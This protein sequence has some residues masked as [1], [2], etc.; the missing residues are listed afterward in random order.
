MQNSLMKLMRKYQRNKIYIVFNHD[1]IDSLYGIRSSRHPRMAAFYRHGISN[2]VCGDDEGILVNTECEINEQPELDPYFTGNRLYFHISDILSF[3]PYPKT[4][5]I[6][7]YTYTLSN[8]GRVFTCH[9]TKLWRAESG[10]L[11]TQTRMQLAQSPLL[12]TQNPKHFSGLMYHLWIPWRHS[13]RRR[14][15]FS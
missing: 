6:L 12:Q 10:L 3:L 4:S 8:R 1:K 5:S 14:G 13:P 9:R 15:P 11:N 7:R 2:P